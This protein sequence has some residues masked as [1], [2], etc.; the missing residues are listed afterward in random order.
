MGQDIDLKDYSLTGRTGRA[1]IDAGLAEATWYQPPIARDRLRQL[2]ERRDGPAIRDTLLWFAL[3]L[4]SGYA[5]YATWGHW[6]TVFP[7]LIYS[8]LYASASDSRWHEASHGT[9][10]RTD[11]MNEWLYEV[12]S[13]MVFRQSAPWRWSH[14]RHHSDTIIVGRDPEIAVPRPPDIPGILLNLFAFKSIPHEF[15]TWMLHLVGRIGAAERE[16][17]P[18]AEYPK[19]FRV[20]RVWAVIYLA[21]IGLA[22]YLGSWLPLFYVGIPTLIGSYM[23]VV[24]GLTQ[25]A[26]LAEDV[27]DH[28][29]NCRTVYMNRVH[30]FL[31]WNMNYHLEHHMFPLVPYHQLPALHEEIKAY[32]PPPYPSIL[33]AY[34]EIIPALVRQT[35]D[36]A[37]YVKRV[38]PKLD[39][40]VG[41]A[42]AQV[43]KFRGGA[44]GGDGLVSV[45]PLEELPRGEVARFDHGE[46]TYAVYRTVNGGLYATDGICTHGSTHLAEGLVIGELIECP[47]HNGRFSI[48][49]GSVQRAPVCRA[50][51][52]YPASE[53]DGT[54][55][56]DLSGVDPADGEPL[57]QFRVVS[58][59]NVATLIRELTLEP[60]DDNFAYVPGDYLQLR[61]PD[62][63]L[64]LSTV[65]VDER[66]AP[67]WAELGIDRLR[68]ANLSPVRRNYSLATNP[69]RDRQLKFNVRLALPPA[70]SG[71][72][73]GRG[74]SYVYSLR[75]G[76]TV[77][78]YGPFGDFHIQDS[79][80]EMVYLGGGAGMAPLRAHLSHLFDSLDTDRRVSFWYGARNGGELFYDDYFRALAERHPNFRFTVA[81][82]DPRP[83]E[84]WDGPTGYVHQVALEQYLQQHPDP[85]GV[86]YYVCGP[87]PMLRAVR[88]MLDGLGVPGERIRYDDFG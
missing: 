38:L 14:T 9:A 56:L 27:L 25:H 13:F 15:R 77:E 43:R 63:T 8:V 30:R 19:V 31:Y 48:V 55:Y 42:G 44:A 11:W 1:A 78:A 49:D 5:M 85:A 62:Y 75:P 68:A 24:Y 47:K 53:R 58:N 73:A 3:L 50:L 10:F 86:E 36:P 17:I 69:A 82:S 67:A 23:V 66:F 74:S 4:A 51:R 83:D 81:L 41:E 80:R 29:L 12:A 33:A 79:E 26:G 71:G 61:I 65:E 59:R 7:V 2:L 70:G 84:D 40:G 37:Y 72:H 60:L 57:H 54:V 52:T 21:V 64:E 20:A 6:Y 46:R 34:R 28:R 45:C 76:D 39:E 32:C 18:E 88:A 87:P 16:Y 35:K 22:V